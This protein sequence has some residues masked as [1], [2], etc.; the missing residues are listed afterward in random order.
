VM[1]FA[2]KFGNTGGRLSEISPNCGEVVCWPQWPRGICRQER[3]LLVGPPIPDRSK[4]I[5]Q[6]CSPWTSTLGL[7]VGI[8]TP[9]RINLILRIF[10]RKP[11]RRQRPAQGCNASKEDTVYMVYNTRMDLSGLQRKCTRTTW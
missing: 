1:S 8:R 6:K 3:K 11:W 9:P 7:G 2:Q 10:Q 4:G 5:G